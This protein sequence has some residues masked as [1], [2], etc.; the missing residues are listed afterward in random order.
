MI[1]KLRPVASIGIYVL[2][3]RPPFARSAGTCQIKL[4]AGKGTAPY[5]SR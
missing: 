2:G 5:H 3:M 4:P 1:L